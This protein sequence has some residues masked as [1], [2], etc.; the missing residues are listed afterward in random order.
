M[1]PSLIRTFFLIS[2]LEGLLAFAALYRIPSES[3]SALLFGFSPARLALGGLVFGLA[4]ALGGVAY[5][6]FRAPGFAEKLV[7]GLD[8]YFVY[9]DRLL[10]A[11]FA[12]SAATL[13]CGILLA[14]PDTSLARHIGSLAAVVERARYVLLWGGILSLQGLAALAWS[15]RETIGAAGFGGCGPWGNQCWH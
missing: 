8:L 4:L 6:A 3:E 13:G 11:L 12:L 1:R 5:G 2:F 15:Y 7:G 9:G 14:L 10:V